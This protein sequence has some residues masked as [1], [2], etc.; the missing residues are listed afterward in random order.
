MDMPSYGFRF[1]GID[2]MLSEI[3][4]KQVTNRA[5]TLCNVGVSYFGS[6]EQMIELI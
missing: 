5:L 6:N 4:K 1:K 3:E 2:W